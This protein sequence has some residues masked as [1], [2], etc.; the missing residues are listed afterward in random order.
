[1]LATTDRAEVVPV[2]FCVLYDRDGRLV[3]VVRCGV[4]DMEKKRVIEPRFRETIK[5][6]GGGSF[7]WTPPIVGHNSI[8][9][10]CDGIPSTKETKN[11]SGRE[12]R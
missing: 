7:C 2:R 4:D 11:L 6:I 10:F 12:F 1:M 8:M 5:T 9:D 3:S